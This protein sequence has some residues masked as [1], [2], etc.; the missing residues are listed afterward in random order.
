LELKGEKDFGLHN[1]ILAK[2]LL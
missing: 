2:V 1:N